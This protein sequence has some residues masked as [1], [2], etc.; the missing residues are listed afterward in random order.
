MEADLEDN[1]DYDSAVSQSDTSFPFSDQ[2]ASMDSGPSHKSYP[3]SNQSKSYSSI[4]FKSTVSPVDQSRGFGHTPSY[5]NTAP[6]RRPSYEHDSK[7]NVQSSHNTKSP[8]S[9]KS[10]RS[11]N[12]VTSTGREPMRPVSSILSRYQQQEEPTG[13]QARINR[14]VRGP[15]GQNYVASL[16][17]KENKEDDVSRRRLEKVI[18]CTPLIP[19]TVYTYKEIIT[20]HEA[21]VFID[22]VGL[23]IHTF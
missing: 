7:T 12:Q 3:W 8:N 13:Y 11:V 23:L 22:A 10:P 20:F 18:Y 21:L 19:L 17:N 4:G 16:L 14:G 6:V 9:P 1:Q 2:S 5:Q 15:V